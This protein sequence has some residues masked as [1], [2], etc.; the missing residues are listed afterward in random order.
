[1]G[2][3]LNTE[4]HSLIF[5]ALIHYACPVSIPANECKK[6][7]NLTEEMREI[8]HVVAVWLSQ[9]DKKPCCIFIYTLVGIRKG[10]FALV[11]GG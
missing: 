8:W 9:H 5:F 7:H 3:G 4:A 2:G 6:R 10:F 1:M 11:A